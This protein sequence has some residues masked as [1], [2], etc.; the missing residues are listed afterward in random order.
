MKKFLITG[1]VAMLIFASCS[2][3]TGDN[4]SSGDNEKQAT[5]TETTNTTETTNPTVNASYFGT[6]APDETKEV[7]DIVFNDGSATPYTPDLVLTAEQKAAAIAVIFYKGSDLNSD[8]N[9]TTVRTLGVGF[10]HQ[11]KL[12]YG[13]G[14]KWCTDKATAYYLHSNEGIPLDCLWHEEYDDTGSL[15]I[16]FGAKENTRL[17]ENEKFCDKNGSDNIEQLNALIEQAKA[18]YEQNGLAVDFSND[19]TEES[20]YPAFYFCKNYKNQKI[21]SE[22]KSRLAGTCFE[23]GWYLPSIAELYH[24]Y[25]CM[26]DS[27]DIDEVSKL[28]GGNQFYTG[29]YWSS[30]TDAILSDSDAYFFDFGQVKL[31]SRDKNYNDSVCAIREF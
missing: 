4:G 12:V 21:G 28:C 13:D 30:S 31:D 7:G 8:D 22:A 11:K 24:I 10:K 9:D 14:L 17:S 29:S 19:T 18:M 16:I 3:S 6:K 20:K 23:D 5:P 26:H 1:L 15:K 2:T 27:V 25:L